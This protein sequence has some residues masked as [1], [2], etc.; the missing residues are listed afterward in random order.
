MRALADVQATRHVDAVS[1]QPIDLAEQFLGIEHH[2]VAN[3][4]PHTGVHDAAR[5]LVQDDFLVA[6]VH[7][8]SGIRPALIAHHPIG[9]LG[10]HVHQLALALI[11]PL[12]THHHQR[13]SRRV[14]HDMTLP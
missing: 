11:T 9:T 5:D 2:A 12:G 13:A 3:G 8:V 4:A 6:D 7:R 14:E 10:E 1:N